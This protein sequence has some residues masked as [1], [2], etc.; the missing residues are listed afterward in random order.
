LFDHFAEGEEGEREG[1]LSRSLRMLKKER[2]RIAEAD[3]FIGGRE[4]GLKGLDGED[5]AA[6]KCQW[7]VMNT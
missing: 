3:V 4:G 1:S 2:I 7:R 5:E 6:E